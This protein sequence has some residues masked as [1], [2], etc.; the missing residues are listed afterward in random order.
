MSNEQAQAIAQEILNQFGGGRA[1][2]MIGMCNKAYGTDEQGNAYLSFRFKAGRKANYCKITLNGLD[3]YDMEIG[4]VHGMNYR[5]VSS[6]ESIYNDMLQ[7]EF[8]QATGL[9]LSL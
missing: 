4:K 5:V 8:E 7:K 9:Y 1:S 3:L 2:M 6:S